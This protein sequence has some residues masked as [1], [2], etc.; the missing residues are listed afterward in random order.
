MP[1]AE[2]TVSKHRARRGDSPAARLG[3]RSHESHTPGSRASFGTY[4]LAA[5]IITASLTFYVF[6]RVSSLHLGYVLTQ[7][8]QEQLQLVMDNRALETEIST[9]SSPARIRELAS[10]ELGLVPGDRLVQLP[11]EEPK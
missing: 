4:L 8:R 5:I 11:R 3:A 1:V 6:L 10:K 9:L 7:S 2:A